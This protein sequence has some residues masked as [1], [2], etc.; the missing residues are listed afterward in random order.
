MVDNSD[1]LQVAI[2]QD[3]CTDS[4]KLGIYSRYFDYRGGLSFSRMEPPPPDAE[5]CNITLAAFSHLFRAYAEM[6]FS[7]TITKPLLVATMDRLLPE[8]YRRLMEASRYYRSRPRLVPAHPIIE[9]AVIQGE[10]GRILMDQLEAA[11]AARQPGE[12]VSL[13]ARRAIPDPNDNGDLFFPPDYF[14]LGNRIHTVTG[15]TATETRVRQQTTIAEFRREMEGN[16]FGFGTHVGGWSDEVL[17]RARETLIHC[18][19]DV[20][21]AEFARTE[22]FTVAAAN[23]RMFVVMKKESYNVKDLDGSWEYC[24]VPGEQ[25]CIYDKMLASKLWLEADYDT[26]MRVAN[27][28]NRRTG[29]T[30]YARERD[31]WTMHFDLEVLYRRTGAVVANLGTGA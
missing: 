14:R 24:C 15:R 5:T 8:L 10:Q 28:I 12:L 7:R 11:F 25:V 9:N 21:R 22:S 30:Q 23:G 13:D 29:Q 2:T 17:A 27:K 3:D 6:P 16:F 4:T 26:F 31:R 1:L 18:L 20:Q 19:S